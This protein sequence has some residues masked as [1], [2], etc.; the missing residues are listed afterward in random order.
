MPAFAIGPVR[1]AAGLAAFSLLASTPAA[2]QELTCQSGELFYSAEQYL[3]LA[4]EAE[5]DR[6]RTNALVQLWGNV[7]PTVANLANAQAATDFSGGLA[8]SRTA[9][10]RALA[11]SAAE[12]SAA[13]AGRSF[14]VGRLNR[15]LASLEDGVSIMSRL[16]PALGT[17]SQMIDGVNILYHS[18]NAVRTGDRQSKVLAIQAAMSLA[19]SRLSGYW[20]GNMGPMMGMAGLLEYSI[21]TFATDA[22]SRYED[23]WWQAYV[24]YARERHALSAIEWAE[25]YQ[26][27]GRAG[28][29]AR[30]NAFWNDPEDTVDALGVLYNPNAGDHLTIA[31][32]AYAEAEYQRV[33]AARYMIEVVEPRIMQGFTQQADR[34]LDDAMAQFEDACEDALEEARAIDAA[35]AL[36]AAADTA[37]PGADTVLDAVFEND[38][39][40]IR[41]AL[42]AG[43]DPNQT[44]DLP[45]AMPFMYAAGFYLGRDPSLAPAIAAL[46]D[47]GGDVRPDVPPGTPEPI[48][49]PVGEG[50]EAGAFAVLDAGYRSHFSSAEGDT[51]I[52]RAVMSGMPGLIHRLIAEGHAVNVTGPDGYPLLISAVN[53]GRADIVSVLLDA[54][55]DPNARGTAEGAPLHL[56]ALRGSADLIPLLVAAGARIDEI[57]TPGTRPYSPLMI[58]AMQGRFDA[59]RALVAAGA[60]PAI[61]ASRGTAADYAR[62]NGHVE[63]A[64]Y[65]DGLVPEQ[66]LVLDVSRIDDYFD[67]VEDLITASAVVSHGFE[68]VATASITSSDPRILEVIEQPDLPLIEWMSREA[69]PQ[70]AL[71]DF[72]AVARGVGEVTLTVSVTDRDGNTISAQR[73]VGAGRKLDSIAEDIAQSAREFDGEG[74]RRSLAGAP[75]AWHSRLLAVCASGFGSGD[76]CPDTTTGGFAIYHMA[77]SGDVSVLQ[78]L[79]ESGARLNYV[80]REDGGSPLHAAV[81]GGHAG[82]VDWLLNAGADPDALTPSGNS[83]IV[84]AAAHNNLA[85]VQRLLAAGAD[86]NRGTLQDGTSALHHAAIHNNRAMI[87]AL[88][89]AGARPGPDGSGHAPGYYAFWLHQ[90]ENLA[91]RLGYGD[92]R[93][94]AE[95]ERRRNEP[96]FDWAEFARRM[97]PA[98]EQTMGE[99]QTAQSQYNAGVAAANSNYDQTMAQAFRD[100][101]RLGQPLNALGNPPPYATPSDA[102]LPSPYAAQQSS[103]DPNVPSF[104][105]IEAGNTPGRQGQDLPD[106]GG[107]L[108]GRQEMFMD[109]ADGRASREILA[110]SMCVYNPGPHELRYEVPITLCGR[111]YYASPVHDRRLIGAVQ[112]GSILRARIGGSLSNPDMDCTP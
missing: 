25:L 40:A 8:T 10:E 51:M 33:F 13:L 108:A 49:V 111:R 36:L 90:D 38:V 84:V 77:F 64:D 62:A 67:D 29:E 31:R 93:G 76:S 94:Y 74:I 106:C 109:F 75:R 55:A 103:R 112:D 71:I 57:M 92:A 95:R 46:R 16:G 72:R 53:G 3:G 56:A 48:I 11:M 5:R 97:Q 28:I 24:G 19:R 27:E 87:D 14:T 68:R 73:R 43:F 98:L 96:D 85:L 101:E 4:T 32:S 2:A 7:T 1:L 9:I 81:L 105:G 59:V 58:A 65:L 100:A 23:Y 45:P 104:D 80:S 78:I 52:R 82:T 79:R 63:I 99:I 30:L 22:W 37:A 44:V 6:F 69:P 89:N 60:D 12:R 34:L 110:L 86:P 18:T 42:A 15:V 102:G 41:E 47:G 88:L 61:R 83:A 70:S 107:G 21:N 50:N 54:G 66:P 20:G 17:A 26:R 91:V 39:A 35:L